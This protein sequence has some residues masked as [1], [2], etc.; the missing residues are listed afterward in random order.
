MVKN[1][2]LI[3]LI[4]CLV[5]FTNFISITKADW[6]PLEDIDIESLVRPLPSHPTGVEV[7]AVQGDQLWVYDEG[8]FFHSVDSGRKWSIVKTPQ[9]T[10]AVG[11]QVSP[12][13]NSIVLISSAGKLFRSD[14]AGHSWRVQS[15][16]QNLLSVAAG[17]QVQEYGFGIDKAIISSDFNHMV[18]IASCQV[19]F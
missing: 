17:T 7:G 12:D 4:L 14:S 1:I 11:L 16:E 9:K 19:F 3:T 13:N 8:R 2:V 5:G 6:P 18:V 15:L 10:R